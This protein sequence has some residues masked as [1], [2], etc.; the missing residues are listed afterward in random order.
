VFLGVGFLEWDS[1]SGIL[2]VGFLEW[3][4]W[5]GILEVRYLEWDSWSGI[6]EQYFASIQSVQVLDFLAVCLLCFSHRDG[7][8]INLVTHT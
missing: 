2:G 6:L 1:W 5:S 3:D 8:K 4:S 7:L